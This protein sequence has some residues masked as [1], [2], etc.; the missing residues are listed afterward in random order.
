[1]VDSGLLQIILI[2]NSLELP[3]IGTP[4]QP[5][6]LDLDAILGNKVT[7]EEANLAP[8]NSTESTASVEIPPESEGTSSE[9]V[10]STGDDERL[11]FEKRDRQLEDALDSAEDFVSIKELDGYDKQLAEW[12]AFSWKVQAFTENSISLSL[13]FATPSQISY[14]H[15]DVLEVRFLVNGETQDS[16]LRCRNLNCSEKELSEFDTDYSMQIYVPKQTKDEYD[17]NMIRLESFLGF[18]KYMTFIILIMMCVWSY[19]SVKPF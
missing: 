3:I 18:A 9:E 10:S 2:N 19:L 6:Y 5:N 8:T 14:L 11:L 15:K 4:N 7:P 1:M 12:K 17:T 16:V 13:E